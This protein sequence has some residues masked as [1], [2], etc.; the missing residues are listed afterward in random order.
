MVLL[1]SQ[2]SQVA[3]EPIKKR[4]LPLIKVALMRPCA[5]WVEIERRAGD[6]DEHAEKPV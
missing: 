5:F 2:A 1:F 3:G 4:L 6:R